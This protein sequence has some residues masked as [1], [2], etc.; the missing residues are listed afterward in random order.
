MD[1]VVGRYRLPTPRLALRDALRAHAGAAADVSDG[2]LAD[3][4]HIGEASG[5]GLLIRLEQMPVSAAASEWLATQPDAAAARLQL[6]TSGD[7]YEVVCTAAPADVDGLVEA[8]RREGLSLTVI[9]G[10]VAEPGLSVSFE[11]RP[12][13]V[14]RRGWTHP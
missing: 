3:A 6:A 4:G 10:L 9:G 5:L 13:R 7:D 2:L 1:E 14:D 12:V 8:A 11:G